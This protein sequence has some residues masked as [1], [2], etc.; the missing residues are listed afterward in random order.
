MK[1]R[2][3]SLIVLLE[4]SGFIRKSFAG[5]LQ[6]YPTTTTLL[7]RV[8]LEREEYE[9]LAATQHKIDDDFFVFIKGIHPLLLQRKNHYS[10][11]ECQ[12]I[13]KMTGAPFRRMEE[14]AEATR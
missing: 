2:Y 14:L 4:E 3:Q 8:L 5:L 9:L 1:L 7:K 13:A 11:Q 6:D 12:Q 10:R